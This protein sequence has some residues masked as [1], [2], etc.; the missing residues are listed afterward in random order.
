MTNQYRLFPLSV[1]DGVSV[2]HT[3]ALMT[4]VVPWSGNSTG[5]DR[6]SNNQIWGQLYRLSHL[7]KSS[8][9]PTAVISV[10]PVP[11]LLAQESQWTVR[12][13]GQRWNS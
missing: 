4:A 12:Q 8:I 9:V 13:D 5:P 10:T 6:V 7:F 11:D 3:L 1:V 2:M